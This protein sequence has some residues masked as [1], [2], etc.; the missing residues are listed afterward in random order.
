MDFI[1]CIMLIG[2]N[3]LILFAFFDD[4]LASFS[5]SGLF[6]LLIW[7]LIFYFGFHSDY[8]TR[9]DWLEPNDT[10]EDNIEFDKY[11]MIRP[12]RTPIWIRYLIRILHIIVEKSTFVTVLL[13]FI[14]L[15]DRSFFI[16]AQIALKAVLE[17]F[18]FTMSFK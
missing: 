10:P 4:F 9:K 11:T 8:T 7:F 5:V 16:G 6:Y 3:C 15:C 14:V 12:W 13:L 18:I 17:N 2:F 1:G